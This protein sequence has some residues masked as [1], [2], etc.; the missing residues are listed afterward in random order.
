MHILRRQVSNIVYEFFCEGYAWLL[1]TNNKTHNFSKLE[2]HGF[3]AFALI[4]WGMHKFL[5]IAELALGG[6]DIVTLESFSYSF[7]PFFL[8]FLLG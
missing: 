5:E 8:C 7:L 6:L 1:D 4:V 3:N 2:I